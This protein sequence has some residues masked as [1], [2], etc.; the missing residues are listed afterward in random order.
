MCIFKQYTRNIS[1]SQSLFLYVCAHILARGQEFVMY[2]LG[3]QGI[4]YGHS[5][6]EFDKYYMIFILMQLV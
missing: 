3:V 1:V 6:V 4:S 2:Y 5:R